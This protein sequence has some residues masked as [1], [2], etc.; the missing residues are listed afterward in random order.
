MPD[1]SLKYKMFVDDKFNKLRKIF[2]YYCILN[3]NALISIDII[4]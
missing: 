4:F 1:V 2:S 3:V